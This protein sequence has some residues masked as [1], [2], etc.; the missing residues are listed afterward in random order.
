[1]VALDE[2]L[3]NTY[4]NISSDLNEIGYSSIRRVTM[5]PTGFYRLLGK[6][7]YNEIFYPG[8]LATTKTVFS[9]IGRG[10]VGYLYIL[11]KG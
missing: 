2:G 5:V 4:K 11:T 6:L 10:K 8:L 9:I 1:M 7:A 3:C